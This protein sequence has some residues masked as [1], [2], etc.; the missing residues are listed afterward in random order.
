[1]FVFVLLIVSA[2]CCDTTLSLVSLLA[3]VKDFASTSFLVLHILRCLF[4]DFIQDNFFLQYSHT[5]VCSPLHISLCFFKLH[6]LVKVFVQSLHCIILLLLSINTVLLS[7]LLLLLS[8]NT[9]L[10]PILLLLLYSF[11][12]IFAQISFK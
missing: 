12:V 6:F 7:M 4:L 10:F 1:M 8:I 9:V 11:V 5:D 3:A 2:I